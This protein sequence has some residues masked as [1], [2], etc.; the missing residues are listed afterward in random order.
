MKDEYGQHNVKN[1]NLTI[2]DQNEPRERNKDNEEESTV[3]DPAEP[4]IIPHP[5]LFHSRAYNHVA[6]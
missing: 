5:F 3:G 2:Q 6:D 1:V 4:H